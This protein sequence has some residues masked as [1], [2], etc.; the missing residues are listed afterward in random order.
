[1]GS[2]VHNFEEYVGRLREGVGREKADGVVKS[3]V[4]VIGAGSNDLIMNYYLT[5]L[6]RVSFSVDEY[7]GFLLQKMESFVQRL[8]TLGARK[9]TIS[10]LPPLG[11]VPIQ[12]TINTV[13]ALMK[14]GSFTRLLGP[15]VCIDQQNADSVS[16]NSRLQA[17]INRMES[18]LEGTRFAY[19]DIYNPVMHMIKNPG[20][21]G[22]T[23]TSIGCCGSG[24]IEMG[25]A[26][27]GGS[28]AD[29]S[30]YLFWDSV[31]PSQATYRALSDQ[32][33]QSLLSQLTN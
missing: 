25:P 8:Y 10:G 7:H 11:C 26:C 17:L 18:S 20:A 22:F 14:T 6:R 1:M 32:L 23:H 3:A 29:T 24:M 12:M 27:N 21:Y 15:R 33:M 13:T 28:C 4:F 16:Y 9:F 30:K 19:V 2:Q 31:H 5:P